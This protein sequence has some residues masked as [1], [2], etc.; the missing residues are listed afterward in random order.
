MTLLIGTYSDTHVV[1][2]ADGLCKDQDPGC[3]PK[4]KYN[5]QKIFPISNLPITILHHGQNIIGGKNIK[6]I[7]SNFVAQHIDSLKDRSLDQ[8]SQLLSNFLDADAK[9][10]L[11]EI[12]HID[13]GIGFWVAGFGFNQKLPR[14]HEIWWKGKND[15]SFMVHNRLILGGSAGKFIPLSMIKK[16]NI[17]IEKRSVKQ[18]VRCH[19][20][21]YEFAE[22]VQKNQTE[23]LLGR[24]KH[25]LVI[26]TAGYEWIIPPL[27][28]V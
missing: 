1:L 10:T 6:E 14:V 7:I 23:I 4:Y 5:L 20:E 25:Q 3:T 27:E 17:D 22:K 26:S 19:N 9:Q 8:I 24:S 15:A 21:L 28:E 18:L 16:H 12:T 13:T 2:T 11:S